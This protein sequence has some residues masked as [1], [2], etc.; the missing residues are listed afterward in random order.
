MNKEKFEDY[1]SVDSHVVTSDVE[2][3]QK[4]CESLVVSGSVEGEKK[5]ANPKLCR[6]LL[7][8]MKR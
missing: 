8:R 7:R 2:T 3:V 1:V 6:A 5:M 4:L